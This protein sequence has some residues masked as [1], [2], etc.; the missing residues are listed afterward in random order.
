MAPFNAIRFE[1]NGTLQKWQVTKTTPE[2]DKYD[3]Q[4]NDALQKGHTLQKNAQ[5][6][7][8]MPRALSQL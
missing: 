1:N 4:K 2:I 8:Y 3:T 6:L 7:P 5:M